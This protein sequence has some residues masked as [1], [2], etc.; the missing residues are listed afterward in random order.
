MLAPTP[1]WA[2]DSE[3]HVPSAGR[4]SGGPLDRPHT[5]AEFEAGII[6]LPTA[7]ISAS[8]RGGATP[9][10]TIGRGDA[11]VQTGAH[12][13]YRGGPDWEIGA[14]GLFGPR[15]T[16]DDQYGGLSGLKRTHSRS[17]L[18]LG[19]EGRYLPFRTRWFETWV[20]M[21]VGGIIIA[22]RFSTDVE[23]VPAIFGNPE[24]TIRTEGFAI[25][26]Q[27]GAQWM[28][29]EKWVTGLA[30][31]A[32]RWILPSSAGCTPIGDCAT[33]TGSIEAFEVGLRLGYRLPL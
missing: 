33:L 22:D 10:G 5:I 2:A 17:Y 11:T 32:D 20:G 30:L 29:A 7:P 3:T 8:Q 24:V 4:L 16:F 18:W 14:G 9:F 25:G 31:R 13:L 19:I 28:F 26:V 12:L 6:A 1:A 27:I 21:T 15:P 23:P